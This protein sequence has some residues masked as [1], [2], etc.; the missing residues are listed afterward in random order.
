MTT[1]VVSKPS[2]YVDLWEIKNHW[3]FKQTVSENDT[4]LDTGEMTIARLKEEL[5]IVEAAL[6]LAVQLKDR[7]EE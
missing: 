6:L 5:K 4:R 7:P 3:F 2:S 1:A